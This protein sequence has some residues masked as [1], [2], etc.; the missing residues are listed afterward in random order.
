MLNMQ[1]VI[2]PFVESYFPECR[3][4][5]MYLPQTNEWSFVLSFRI[6]KPAEDFIVCPPLGF[7][8]TSFQKTGRTVTFNMFISARDFQ[9]NHV[10]KSDLIALN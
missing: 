9:D 4:A 3:V 6:P 10:R 1:D 5:P 7:N 2:I 8:V